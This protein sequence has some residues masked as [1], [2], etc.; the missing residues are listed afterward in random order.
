M[1]RQLD[2]RWA[3][4][5]GFALVA[6]ADLVACAGLFATGHAGLALLS[7]SFA[8]IGTILPAVF[9][10]FESSSRHWFLVAGVAYV[11]ILV[12]DYFVALGDPMGLVRNAGGFENRGL[13]DGW[14]LIQASLG[15]M[16]MLRKARHYAQNVIASDWL[17]YDNCWA[18]VLDSE[19]RG[20]LADTSSLAIILANS[21]DKTSP[22]EGE[23]RDAISCLESICAGIRSSFSNHCVIQRYKGVLH[24]HKMLSGDFRSTKLF[25][26]TLH[27]G[28]A[29]HN[30]TAISKKQEKI[31][32][33]EYEKYLPV[34]DLDQLFTMAEGLQPFLIRKVQEW[35]TISG[36]CFLIKKQGGA[37]IHYDQSSLIDTGPVGA[38][39][40]GF[41]KW[42]DIASNPDLLNQV[43]WGKVKSI[44]RAIEKVYRTYKGDASKLLDCCRQV[45]FGKL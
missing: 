11:A 38:D 34:L 24:N 41:V 18:K 30:S 14:N 32:E 45:S 25:A 37:D 13:H 29:L 12:M 2:A 1:G 39:T 6:V 9:A 7:G 21:A 5:A 36:G 15:A 26:V 33:E 4:S 40:A 19:T 22:V 44:H 31:C 17:A 23:G 20:S 3:A 27:Q 42:V 10:F 43:K 28:I 8:A 16:V 35:A